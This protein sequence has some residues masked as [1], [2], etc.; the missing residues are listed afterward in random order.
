MRSTRTFAIGCDNAMFGV[1]YPHFESVFPD[2]AAQV[3]ALVAHP[4]ITT[5]VAEKIL[6]GNAARVYGFDL[7]RL[8]PDTERVGF[9]IDGKVVNRPA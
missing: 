8:Q 5:E 3:D 7:A 4:A 6:Y 1:D 9:D 2:T